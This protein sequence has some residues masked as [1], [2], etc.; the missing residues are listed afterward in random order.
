M[1]LDYTKDNGWIAEHLGDDYGRFLNS[2]VPPIFMNSLHVFDG[3][4]QGRCG[5]F[6]R[7]G[8]VRCLNSGDLPSRRSYYRGPQLLHR[9]LYSA[10]L[11]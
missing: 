8:G 11:L 1:D 3:A 9:G 10:F 5:V 4:R 6:L 7:Y 2:V